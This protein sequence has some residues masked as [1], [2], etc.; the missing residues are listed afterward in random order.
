MESNSCGLSADTEDP[1]FF[2]SEFHRLSHELRTP[3]NAINGFAELLLRQDG[4][5]PA[6][7]DYVRAILSSSAVLTQAVVDHLDRAEAGVVP[8]PGAAVSP[9]AQPVPGRSPFTQARRSVSARA[10]RRS[11]AL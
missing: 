6:A 3:L 10:L 5:S 1:K 8:M 9:E 7:A 4:L 11:V 2:T